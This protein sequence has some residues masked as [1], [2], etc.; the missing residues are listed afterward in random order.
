MPISLL[1]VWNDALSHPPPTESPQIINQMRTK[2]V[3][4]APEK[5]RCEAR[6]RLHEN[7]TLPVS[8]ES[9]KFVTEK[10]TTQ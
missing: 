10:V 1:F 5:N 9:Q 3:L 7:G 6:A 2:I 4:W 8:M